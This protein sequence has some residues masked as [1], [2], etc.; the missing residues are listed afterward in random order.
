LDILDVLRNAID[1]PDDFTREVAGILSD[2]NRRLR[3]AAYEVLDCQLQPSDHVLARLILFLRGPDRY[4]QV[5]EDLGP[6]SDR[7]ILKHAASLLDK[8]APGVLDT[9]VRRLGYQLSG[10]E[11]T[12]P[13]LIR[14]LNDPSA[15]VRTNTMKAFFPAGPLRPEMLEAIFTKWATD[16]IRKFTCYLSRHLADWRAPDKPLPDRVMD[17]MLSSFDRDKDT[18]GIIIQLW[19]QQRHLPE[20]AIQKLLPYLEDKDPFLVGDVEMVLTKQAAFYALLPGLRLSA[21]RSLYSIWFERGGKP[22]A[23]QSMYVADGTLFVDV[24][25]G[26]HEV[27]FSDAKQ[28]RVFLG[29][30]EICQREMFLPL[31]RYD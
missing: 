11:V 15:T 24:S 30:I 31:F 20:K 22:H 14:R 7:L 8:E 19:V 29:H 21:L 1:L 18:R 3:Q 13:I 23:R 25:Q 17:A 2:P 26:L 6:K 5:L 10:S 28:E 9:F 16:D 12:L 4:Q 27:R